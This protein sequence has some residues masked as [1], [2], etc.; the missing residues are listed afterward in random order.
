LRSKYTP[1][2]RF[3]RNH[4]LLQCVRLSA[5]LGGDAPL[6]EHAIAPHINF[7][8]AFALEFLFSND[9][10]VVGLTLELLQAALTHYGGLRATWHACVARCVEGLA[11][12]AFACLPPID[13]SSSS[14]SSSSS[15]LAAALLLSPSSSRR[16]APRRSVLFDK[17]SVKAAALSAFAELVEQL[18][19]ATLRHTAALLVAASASPSPSTTDANQSAT[20]TTLLVLLPLFRHADP[21]VRAHAAMVCGAVVRGL[22][23]TGTLSPPEKAFIVAA[24]A[25]VRDALGDASAVALRQTVRAIG[26]RYVSKKQK[27]LS[28]ATAAHNLV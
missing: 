19:R 11:A 21:L 25:A 12:Q 22:L 10:N 5:E 3:H 15:P 9:H 16:N 20:H 1:I 24:L 2:T 17:V 28:S 4:S 27:Q 26:D 18:P 6:H 7:V 14:A 23:R 8:A 13:A